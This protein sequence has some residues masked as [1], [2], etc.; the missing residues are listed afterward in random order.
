MK[1]ATHGGVKG[2]I[3]YLTNTTISSKIPA[4]DDHP[5]LAAELTELLAR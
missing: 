5:R 3:G 1:C 4:D 2:R